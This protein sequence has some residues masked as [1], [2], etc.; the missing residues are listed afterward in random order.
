MFL[1]LTTALHW[2]YLETYRTAQIYMG[3]EL[4]R[5]GAEHLNQNP[6]GQGLALRV[7]CKAPHMTI[8]GS[9]GYNL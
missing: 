4:G 1:I 5:C 2:K 6:W 8:A 7:L 9:R 3:K